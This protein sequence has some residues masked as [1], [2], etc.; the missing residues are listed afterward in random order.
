MEQQI[1][2]DAGEFKV[3]GCLTVDTVAALQVD[4]FDVIQKSDSPVIF[5]LS[6]ADVVGS[7]AMALLI[8]WQRKAQQLGKQVMFIDA[9]QHLL[10]MARVSGV[11]EIISFKS[12]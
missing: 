7:A 12:P 3:V 2:D 4:G 8:S 5:D 6:E 11:E 10:E 1:I 9:P